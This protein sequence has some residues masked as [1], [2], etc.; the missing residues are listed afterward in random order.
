MIEDSVF[1]FSK[2]LRARSKKNPQAKPLEDLPSP[3]T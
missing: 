2:A 3:Q 1:N